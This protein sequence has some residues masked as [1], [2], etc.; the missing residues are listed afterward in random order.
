M[1]VRVNL[2]PRELD[3]VVRARR[4]ARLSA[5]GVVLV[6]AVLGGLY[7]MQVAAVNEAE[8]ERAEVETRI[9]QA[10]QELAALGEFRELKDRHDARSELLSVAMAEEISWARILNDLSLAFPSDA[11]L[12]TLTGAAEEP[13][14]LAEGEVDT[15]PR[16]GR[17]T[18]T[19]YSLEEYAPGVE[20][21]LLDFDTARGFFNSYLQTATTAEIGESEV[22]NFNGTIDLD[23]DAYTGRYA[24]GLPPEV[25][26]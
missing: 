4:I 17:I 3:A 22:T 18:T 10:R 25:A 16:I 14:E 19:G 26:Q 5:L 1:S 13:V 23:E 8:R 2:L 9:A 24:N 20:S 6:A 21:L 15:G 7:A 11:S 12:L